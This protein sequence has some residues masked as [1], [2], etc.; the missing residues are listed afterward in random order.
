MKKAQTKIKDI[1]KKMKVDAHSVLE[2]NAMR[3][4]PM[5]RKQIISSDEEESDADKS[6]D[7]VA[8][9][10]SSSTSTSSY[11]DSYKKTKRNYVKHGTHFLN[12]WEAKT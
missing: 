2:T 9:E 11:M 3:K 12:P 10:G 7:T 8:T 5:K 4:K 1:Y 6:N